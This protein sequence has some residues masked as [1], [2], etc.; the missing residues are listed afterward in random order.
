MP[1]RT[2]HT[3]SE[4]RAAADANE[5]SA[6]E[7]RTDML[8]YRVFSTPDGQE[9]LKFMRSETIERRNAPNDSDGALREFEAVRRFVA[10]L[11]QRIAR[12]IQPSKRRPK[13]TD[14]SGRSDGRSG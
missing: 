8:H 1:P 3:W 9:L 4:V 6:D 12:A 11:E 7:K 10:R 2:G 13:A 14:A 5:L